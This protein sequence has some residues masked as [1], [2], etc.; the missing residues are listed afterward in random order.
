VAYHFTFDV[1]YKKIILSFQLSD[2]FLYLEKFDNGAAWKPR[3][4]NGSF[5]SLTRSY[6]LTL[7]YNVIN[8]FNLKLGIGFRNGS[9]Q[10]LMVMEKL[11]SMQM[12]LKD[13]LLISSNHIPLIILF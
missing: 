9:K 5:S 13:S 2:E 1:Y 10:P 7:G 6:W 12:I 8:N 4:F 11:L 3:R